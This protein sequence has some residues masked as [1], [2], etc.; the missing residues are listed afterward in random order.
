MRLPSAFLCQ[1]LLVTADGLKEYQTP[2]TVPFSQ[3]GLHSICLF[4]LPRGHITNYIQVFLVVCSIC[5]IFA[6]DY[7]IV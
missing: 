7:S 3:C 1:Y 4:S 5:C 6:N 2:L